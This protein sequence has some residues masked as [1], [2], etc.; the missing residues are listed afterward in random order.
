MQKPSNK[1]LTSNRNP[2][3]YLSRLVVALIAVSINLLSLS[4]QAPAL[5]LRQTPRVQKIDIQHIDLD[6]RFDFFK[7]QAIGNASITLKPLYATDTIYLDAGFLS[8]QNIRIGRKNLRF[9]CD[10]NDLND[11][12]RI[13]LHRKHQAGE[14]IV[15]Q[16][17]YHSNYHNDSDPN[18][19]WGSFGKGL[20]F[21]SPSSTEPRKRRQIWSIGK[22][23]GN[24]YWFPSWDAP[25]DARTCTMHLRVENPLTAIAPGTLL[26]TNNNADGTRTFHWA[27]KQAHFNHQTAFVVGTYT[28]FRHPETCAALYTYS[29]PDE[30]EASKASAVRLPDMV[31]FFEEITGQ[32]YPFEAYKQVFVQD[33][34][35][36][37][38]HH[39]D[40]ATISENMVDDYGTHADFF[41]LWDGVEA[42]DLAAQWFGNLLTPA[43]WSEEWLSQSFALYFDC[44]YTEHKN[45]REEMMLW[46]RQFQQNTCQL[47]WQSGLRR[48]I[49][50]QHYD[51]P[52]NICFDN[53][54]LRGALVLHLLRKEIGEANWR[55]AIQL[56]VKNN[57]GKAVTTADFQK[58]VEAACG[59]PMDWFFRQWIYTTGQPHFQ[60]TQQF[61][62]SKKELLL[63]VRQIQ[64]PDSSHNYPQ[65]RFFQGNLDVE[66]DGRIETIRLEATPENEFRFR[67]ENEPAFVNFDVENSWIR[68]LDM[69]QRMSASLAQFL[70]S[71][72][73]L[74]RRTAM[75]ELAKHY[76]NDSTTAADKHRIVE[77]FRSV[78]VS[79]AYWR[80]RYAALLTLQNMSGTPA[81]DDSTQAMLLEIIQKEKSWM[82]A[83][84]IG[85]LG[86]SED[87]RHAELYLTCLKDE[88]DRVVN[89]AAIAL[90]KS[91][92]PEAFEALLSLK[93]KPSWKNQS[94]IATLNG[95]RELGD[96][97]A[98]PLALEALR[99][100]PAGARWTL[101]TPVWDFRLSAAEALR[102]L[103]KGNEGYQIVNQR[104]TQSVK[105]NDINDIFSNLLLLTTLGDARALQH[106][107]ALK[108]K[109]KHD[110][111]AIQALVNYETQLLEQQKNNKP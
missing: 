99:D 45:G 111:N 106:F 1:H 77:T 30:L 9:Q 33:F 94:L 4:A 83:A 57:A 49:V 52:A 10:S 60:V 100:E 95:L 21:F 38:G 11:N 54:A 65:T 110:P 80:L 46:N 36:G 55:K 97:R 84:A 15:L 19:L 61:D 87:P 23:Q 85:F 14:T 31:C 25:T 104:F 79:H 27:M 62:S 16:I 101:A 63:L 59:K 98:L 44:L 6:L 34:P 7:K 37:G 53:F 71:R 28:E 93:N 105:E 26:G 67:Q 42:Q 29:Y 89:A 32:P 96:P 58:A 56:Y 35:W 88:S 13:Q 109:F 66:I 2:S 75:L 108:E 48:P 43:D 18:N 68:S 41:Y 3:G 102:A 64:Q 72:D 40:M 69:P 39:P 51:D 24:R 22:P 81:N 86:L 17:S 5:P 76:S 74:A 78:I 73:V 92:S 12:L 70:Y 20:R 90:G 82:R 8:I 50:T 103:G 91:K 107:P 47:D